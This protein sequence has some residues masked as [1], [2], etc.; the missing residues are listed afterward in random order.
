MEPKV[1]PATSVT[2]NKC[3]ETS[4]TTNQG[5]SLFV[6]TPTDATLFF[7]DGAAPFAAIAL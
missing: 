1:S 5:G 2:T 7:A 4:Q 6:T 3:R